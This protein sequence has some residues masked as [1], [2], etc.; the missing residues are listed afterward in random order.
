MI[1]CLMKEALPLIRYRTRD[2]TALHKEPCPCGRTTTRMEALSGRADD[3]LIIRGV[4]VFPSHIEEVLESFDKI[5][6]H[7]QITLDTKDYLDTALIQVEL[8]D[9]ELLDS[10][11]RMNQLEREISRRM[12]RA[13][14]LDCKIKL[15]AP[16]SLPRF[17]GKARRVIDNRKQ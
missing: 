4:N 10:Y 6:P 2:I 5:S 1:T 16:G 7:Y 13:I 9:A 3:M 15:E 11:A 8:N 14:G 17:E 12:R